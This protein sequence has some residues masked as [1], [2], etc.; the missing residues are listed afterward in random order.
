MLLVI[1]DAQDTNLVMRN[2]V[3]VAIIAF[4]AILAFEVQAMEI[5]LRNYFEVF[6]PPQSRLDLKIDGLPLSVEL[7]E[8]AIEAMRNAKETLDTDTVFL[9]AIQM[10]PNEVI[11][12]I[13]EIPYHDDALIVYALNP[14]K[15]TFDYKFKLSSE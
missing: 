13:L 10:K 14:N 12:F 1:R 5:P 8:R 4:L 15:K 7:L 9:K 11:Y 3:R 6:N 2:N